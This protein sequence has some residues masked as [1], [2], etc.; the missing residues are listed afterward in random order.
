[1][2]Q[3]HPG[4]DALT[5]SHVLAL[6]RRTRISPTPIHS[7]FSS[8]TQTR[9]YYRNIHRHLRAVL[10]LPR[11]RRYPSRTVNA[12]PRTLEHVHAHKDTDRKLQQARRRAFCRVH[13]YM[14]AYLYA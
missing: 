5:L 4:L 11:P 12:A 10:S 7:Y 1:M 2:T 14:C 3:S 9:I 8:P 13:E 6:P